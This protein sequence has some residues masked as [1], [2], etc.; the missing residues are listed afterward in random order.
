MCKADRDERRIKV[1]AETTCAFLA[2]VTSF[3]CPE[4]SESVSA[5]LTINK[6]HASE[7]RFCASGYLLGAPR[8]HSECSQ[9]PASHTFPFTIRIRQGWL[10]HMLDG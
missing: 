10:K 8:V 5:V 9:H 7:R 3:G 1:R 2:A 6:D 4:F